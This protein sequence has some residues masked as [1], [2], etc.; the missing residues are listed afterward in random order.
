MKKT[1]FEYRDKKKSSSSLFCLT[2]EGTKEQTF[3]LF[4]FFHT[5]KSY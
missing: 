3:Q 2:I 4:L 1:C 5:L